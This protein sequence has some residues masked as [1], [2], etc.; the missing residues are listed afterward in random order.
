V[1]DLQIWAVILGVGALLV[2]GAAWVLR[3]DPR[4]N[5]PEDTP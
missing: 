4:F 2:I 3:D 5:P 1:T